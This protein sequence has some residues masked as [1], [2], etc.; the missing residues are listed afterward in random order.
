M[1]NVSHIQEKKFRI[2]CKLTTAQQK[3]IVQ[4]VHGNPF[5]SHSVIAKYFSR[6]FG[7]KIHRCIVEINWKKRKT[8]ALQG[9]H[10]FPFYNNGYSYEVPIKDL[11]AE[12]KADLNLSPMCDSNND[13]CESP[14]SP[15][16]SK[17]TPDESTITD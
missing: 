6:K 5:K 11:D 2:F 3:E 14:T 10:N 15:V 1:L 13:A 7:K 4:Y 8:I 16:T 12:E 9:S 17:E